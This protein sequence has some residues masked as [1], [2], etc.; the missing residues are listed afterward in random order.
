LLELSGEAD[1][2]REGLKRPIIDAG[3]AI[4]AKWQPLVK[5]AKDFADTIRAAISAWETTKLR[6]AQA[7]P[8]TIKGAAGRAASVK[9]RRVV[10]AITNI[11]VLFQA[12]KGRPEV[13]ALFME[14]A[15]KIV[16]ANQD[17]LG[18]TIEQRMDVR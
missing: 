16:D 7:V 14:L 2:Q 15:Q 12:L 11:D 3:K 5:K 6:K 10:T 17:V 8:T 13:L 18:V 9:P 1:K 4:D